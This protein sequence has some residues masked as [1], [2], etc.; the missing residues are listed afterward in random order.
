VGTSGTA[1]PCSRFSVAAESV[2][3]YDWLQFGGDPQ[4]SGNNTAETALT[5]ANVSAL[6]QKYQVTL[7][8]TADG[9]PVFLE[10]VA[11]PAGLKDLLFVTTRDGRVI[12]LDAQTGAQIWSHQY[13]AGTCQINNTGG[14]CYTTSSPAIDPSGEVVYSYGL[15]GNVHK[16]RVGD[17][18]EIIGGGWPS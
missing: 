8:A 6:V 13:G 12:A 15:D 1:L 11:T 18:T 3:A 17:G 14:A 16:Y 2:P 5:P 10:D 9:A 4:H 7:Q